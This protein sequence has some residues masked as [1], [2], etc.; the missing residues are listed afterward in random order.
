[1]PQHYSVVMLW[2]RLR[3]L[4]FVSLG[5][6]LLNL[7]LVAASWSRSYFAP[8]GSETR[9]IA[10]DARTNSALPGRIVTLVATRPMPGKGD[11][12]GHLWVSWPEPP[13]G[14]PQGSSE[15]GFFAD[16]QVQAASA[17]AGSLLA[18]WGAVTG[19]VP[20][21]G[22]LVEDDGRWRHVQFEITA[23]EAA[24]QAALAVDRRWRDETRYSL[25]PGL[26]ALGGTARTYSCQ[27][28][29]FEVAEAL[30]LKRAK[31]DWTQ[32]PMGAF[33]DLLDANSLAVPV[34]R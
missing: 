11:F 7:G 1:M 22:R 10:V 30:G 24:Y 27:D 3:L 8:G 2:H 15:S 33:L 20:V 9:T 31:R 4:M 12:V 28:Y 5:W 19:Q 29:V 32:F 34:S 25:R 14:A 6:F 17:L 23:D 21:P 13:P 16:D 26:P 18:P